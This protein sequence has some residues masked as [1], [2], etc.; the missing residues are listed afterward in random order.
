MDDD[1]DDE[2]DDDDDAGSGSGSSTDKSDKLQIGSVES[3]DVGS[4]VE[5]S[6]GQ[7]VGSFVKFSEVMSLYSNVGSESSP[8]TLRQQQEQKRRPKHKATK[9]LGL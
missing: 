8:S 4:F 3:C 6:A 5:E 7:D 1:I 2:V 9:P